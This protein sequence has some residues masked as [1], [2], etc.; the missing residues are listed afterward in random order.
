MA[1]RS[2]KMFKKHANRDERSHYTHQIGKDTWTIL[3]VGKDTGMQDSARTP[4][5]TDT[6]GPPF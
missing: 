3:R 4:G 6:P 5:G 1:N 2:K